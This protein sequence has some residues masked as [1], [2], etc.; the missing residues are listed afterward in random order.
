M[1]K[2]DKR[3]K[4]KQGRLKRGTL[5]LA[6]ITLVLIGTV[7]GA[8]AAQAAG[9]LRASAG[10]DGGYHVS[11][12]DGVTQNG[13]T[14]PIANADGSKWVPASDSE[15]NNT[16]YLYLEGAAEGDDPVVTL[17]MD[18][19]VWT[20][21]FTVVDS[22]TAEYYVTEFINREGD[23]ELTTDPSYEL[24]DADGN[25]IYYTMTG[26]NGS[27]ILYNSLKGEEP[28]AFGD[29]TLTK[30]VKD[31]EDN[32]LTS[33]EDATR[34]RFTISL[35]YTLEKTIT[36]NGDADGDTEV[37]EGSAV[38]A[39]LLTG[40]QTYGDIIIDWTSE[41]STFEGSDGGTVITTV[42]TGS[43]VT[44]LTAGESVSLSGLPAGV[45]YE[46]TEAATEG[47]TAE[48]SNE[49]GTIAADETATV[50]CTNTKE[51]QGD[52]PEENV[53]T[54]IVKKQVS[55][56]DGTAVEN[57][58]GVFSMRIS[59]SE[60]KPRT[61]YSYAIYDANGNIVTRET[62]D[63]ETVDCSY[64]CAALADGSAD[65]SFTLMDGQ[66]AVFIGLPVGCRYQVMEE[67]AGDY[68]ASYALSGGG[69]SRFYASSNGANYEAGT[70]LATARETL[71]EEEAGD[72]AEPVTVTFT[73][74]LPNQK[75][76]DDKLD[77]TVKKRWQAVDGNDESAAHEGEEITI[78]LL[79]TLD[80]SS[81]EEADVI[82][83]AFLNGTDDGWT[84]TFRDL[85]RYTD[86][87]LT[88]YYYIKEEPVS[89]YSAILSVESAPCLDERGSLL[90]EQDAEG[91]YVLDGAGQKILDYDETKD[92][93]FTVTNR[94]SIELPSTGGI[95]TT[96]FYVIGIILVL[97][98]GVL[99][100]VK[101][102]MDDAEE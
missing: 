9:L 90:Y 15:D 2:A 33:A 62:E 54:V 11:T 99:L 100:I 55:Y 92:Y 51:E 59:L 21:Y 7:F 12:K 72:S 37:T 80:P 75:T 96:I 22:D 64:S 10:E 78:Y 13:E 3:K 23:Y 38:I 42:Y 88:Y 79:R 8:Y 14:T 30:V 65:V 89:G 63:G 40:A 58:Q 57:D 28:P 1:R 31:A 25:A 71:D 98:A 46:I 19:N 50:T 93:S 18:G 77:V 52:E 87:G 81:L 27:V 45:E 60:L 32:V 39:A 47:Y 29:L 4:T 68:T 41:S 83:T 24:V 70:S 35:S 101:K 86:G 97:G 94:A 76:G 91:N 53:G 5:C 56:A 20:Y 85:E 61:A 48:L 69:D 74:T 6:L 67:A 84:Y 17:V 49:K 44:Y 16:Y 34:F 26:S 73:N 95:G 43:D 102:R 66:Y 82:G 36:A